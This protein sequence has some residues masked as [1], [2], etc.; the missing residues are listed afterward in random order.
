MSAKKQKARGVLPPGLAGV[1]SRDQELRPEKDGSV[2]FLLLDD[3]DLG[4]CIVQ[5]TNRARIWMNH[6][7]I[8]FRTVYQVASPESVHAVSWDEESESLIYCHNLSSTLEKWKVPYEKALIPTSEP[9]SC[10]SCVRA[11]AAYPDRTWLPVFR[12]P[13]NPLNVPVERRWGGSEYPN[14]NA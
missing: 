13:W 5:A 12:A 10:P 4:E 6:H 2:A 9:V 14:A 7:G 8:P 3:P 11:V 1:P